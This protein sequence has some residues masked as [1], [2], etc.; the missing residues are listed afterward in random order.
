MA[1]RPLA[2]SMNPC[3]NLMFHKILFTFLSIF[4]QNYKRGWNTGTSAEVYNNV[5]LQNYDVD[6][7][8][9]FHGSNEPYK[10]LF[11]IRTNNIIYINQFGLRATCFSDRRTKLSA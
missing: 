3:F 9:E 2:R 11:K 8:L 10:Q 4:T 6:Q 5:S 1:H 7:L